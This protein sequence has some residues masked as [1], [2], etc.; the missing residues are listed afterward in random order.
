[1]RKSFLCPLFFIFYSLQL[2]AAENQYKVA[3]DLTNVVN[4]RVKVVV[5]VPP[6]Q[7][8]I[9]VYCL[10][11]MVPGT[12]SIYDF[13]RFIAEIKAFDANGNAL[14]IVPKNVNEFEISN[15]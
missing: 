11:K 13:G 1:M 4:D 10:P 9:A 7:T 15:A 14:K 5:E 3:I 8:D 12:Y 2:F 6:V